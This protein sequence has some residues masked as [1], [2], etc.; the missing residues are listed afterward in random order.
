MKIAFLFIAEAYQAYHGAAVLLE[1]RELPGV[2]V[3]AFHND[4]ETPEH[5]AR[6]AKAWGMEDV[7][8]ERLPASASTRFVQRLRLFGF[9]KT[10]VLRQNE[11]RLRSYDAVVSLEEVAHVLFAG[12]ARPNRPALIFI[13][14][15]AGDRA[16]PSMADSGR[17]DLILVKGTKDVERYLAR[18]WAR[19]GHIAATG[20]VKLETTARMRT[21]AQALF[22][23]NR[24]VTLYNPHKAR[25]QGSWK[26][27]A[28]PLLELF[29]QPGADNLIVA[30]HVKMFRRRSRRVRDRLRSRSRPNILV[31]PGSP[32][33]L[34]GTYI[35]TADIYL[36]DVS[37]QVYDFLARPR[38]CVFLNAHGTEWRNDPH[39]ANWHL[40]EVID[41]PADL[42]A[43]LARAPMLHEDYVARQ[44]ELAA[45][46]NGQTEGA[47]RRSAEAIIRFLEDGRVNT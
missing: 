29:Q 40:G 33:S 24:P 25:G 22:P 7:R 10:P 13:T 16:F 43:A 17:F 8:S 34:D 18:G 2:E 6:I 19:R 15:G 14:H 42:E 30:P 28:E 46:S 35:E 23:N 37:S 20:N 9:E 27:F 36:G 4:S 5:L 12:H 39:F 3:H 44:Q 11:E 1:L 26:R 47:A 38:P 21:T 32:A 45:A 31:D 41:D